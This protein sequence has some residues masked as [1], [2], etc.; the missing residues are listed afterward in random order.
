MESRTPS[1]ISQLICIAKPKLQSDEFNEQFLRKFSDENVRLE[2]VS[3]II[4]DLFNPLV[5]QLQHD[6]T[7]EFKF[8]GLKET[9]QPPSSLAF[10]GKRITDIRDGEIIPVTCTFVTELYANVAPSYHHLSSIHTKQQNLKM[11]SKR[12]WIYNLFMQVFRASIMRLSH[13]QSF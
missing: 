12:P 5:Q 4:D 7:F 11:A 2:K 8:C 10:P 1:S 6:A 9:D 3:N 13:K